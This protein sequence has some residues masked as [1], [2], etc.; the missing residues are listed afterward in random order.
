MVLAADGKAPSSG[1][2][3]LP[4]AA[5]GWTEGLTPTYVTFRNDTSGA[6]YVDVPTQVVGYAYTASPSRAITGTLSLTMRVDTISGT[7][8]ILPVEPCA[9]S[10]ATVRPFIFSHRNDWSGEF[11]RW[12]SNPERM[13]LQQ[14]TVSLSIPLTPDR[15]SSVFGKR[16]TAVPADFNSALSDVSSLG[17]TFGS[18]CAFGHGVSVTNGSARWTLT[19]YKVS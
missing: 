4:L 14:G 7:P 2:V 11:S 13:L 9:A 19:S 17:V 15:W 1:P 10:G 8:S 16:G 5:R 18:D 6:L 12:W 3:V